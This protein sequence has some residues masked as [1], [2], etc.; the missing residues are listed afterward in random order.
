MLAML[1]LS[2]QSPLT[3]SE[4]LALPPAEAGAWALA[5]LE[6]GPIV[7]AE[8]VNDRTE[9][10]GEVAMIYRE[11]ASPVAFGCARRWWRVAFTDRQTPSI[12]HADADRSARVTSRSSGYEVALNSTEQ[13]PIDGY[14]LVSEG[15]PVAVA[16][17]ALRKLRQVAAGESSLAIECTDKTRSDICKS[18]ANTLHELG[19]LPA[20]MVEYHNG[21]IS[22]VLG[23][24]GQPMTLVMF[25]VPES[26]TMQVSRFLPAPF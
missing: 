15:L 17:D 20:R 8:R 12:D 25:G 14:A 10:S 21:P 2:A 19:S 4:A 7:G 16:L 6:H 11:A 18:P 22:I 13:C 23:V 5:G 24:P 1:L 26:N 9:P 3:V